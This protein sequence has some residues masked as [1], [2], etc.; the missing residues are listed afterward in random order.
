MAICVLESSQDDSQS[1]IQGSADASVF[2]H[3]R[4]SS[5]ALHVPDV[6]PVATTMC[7][8]N[9]RYHFVKLWVHIPERQLHEYTMGER[10]PLATDMRT[11][12]QETSLRAD[13]RGR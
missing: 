10:S 9:K 6:E 12:T 13:A 11:P 1:E 3:Q 2:N 8:S 4:R 7:F 5:R